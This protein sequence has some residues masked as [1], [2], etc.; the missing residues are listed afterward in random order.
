[1]LDTAFNVI[2][3]KHGTIDAYLA[4]VLGVD[5]VAQERLRARLLET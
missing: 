3:D 1:Y 4:D 2:H 5:D